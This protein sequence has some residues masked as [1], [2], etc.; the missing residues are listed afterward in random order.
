MKIFVFKTTSLFILLIFSFMGLIFIVPGKTSSYYAANIDKLKLI[1]NL[2]PPRIVLIGGS[3][4]AL[5]VD[6]KKI[7]NIMH[8]KVINMGLHASLGL[9]YMLKEIWPYLNPEDKVV[10]IPEYA[11]FFYG[12]E[13]SGA[14]FNELLS[15][16]PAQVKNIP[17]FFMLKDMISNIPILFK[18]KMESI[19]WYIQSCILKKRYAEDPV[20]N[21]YAFNDNGDAIGHL[22]RKSPGYKFNSLKP[23]GEINEKSIH[24]LNEFNSSA[25]KNKI[26]V[27]FA[28]PSYAD[29]AYLINS[30]ILK[31]LEIKLKLALEM[32]IV[33]NLQE[34][35]VPY[36]HIYDSENHL[37]SQGRTSRTQ[38]LIRDLQIY[39][40]N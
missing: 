3:G 14:A 33:N 10:I 19:I 39:N 17:S 32:P 27:Y 24:V 11:L 1:K 7:Q 4:L 21:R 8:I 28:Y 38:R 9:P 22:N 5:G 35:I 15:C 29:S 13:G 25:K 36:D 2:V 34:N 31:S 30:K 16:D 6:S 20:Y 23:F 18:A 12:L 37:N 26:K 40:L